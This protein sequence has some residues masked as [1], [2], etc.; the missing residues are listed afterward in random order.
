MQ[1]FKL[2]VTNSY[3]ILMYEFSENIVKLRMKNLKIVMKN[4][5]TLGIDYESLESNY[6]NKALSTMVINKESF[7][8]IRKILM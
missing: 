7:Q 5:M 6:S 8:L 3:N 1:S 2:L 4:L